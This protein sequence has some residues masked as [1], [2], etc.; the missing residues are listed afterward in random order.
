MKIYVKMTFEAAENDHAMKDK[1][2]FKLS[3]N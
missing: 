2:D 1:A 3:I